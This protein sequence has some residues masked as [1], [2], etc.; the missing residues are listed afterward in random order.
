MHIGFMAYT[1]VELHLWCSHPR[2]ACWH[3]ETEILAVFLYFRRSIRTQEGTHSALLEG[4]R[5]MSSEVKE[6]VKGAGHSPSRFLKLPLWLGV[7]TKPPQ[8][9]EMRSCLDHE[10]IHCPSKSCFGLR[11]QASHDGGASVLI[12]L[13]HAFRDCYG[14][15]CVAQIHNFNS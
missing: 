2:A 12:C 13:R 8:S 9:L 11:W 5:I 3:L 14:L 7:A 4:G 6:L 15:N 1:H 10:G